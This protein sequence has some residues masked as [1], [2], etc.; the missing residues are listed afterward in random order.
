MNCRR[1]SRCHRVGDETL[2]EIGIWCQEEKNLL[3]SL[4]NTNQFLGFGPYRYKLG[5]IWTMGLNVLMSGLIR[6]L[7]LRMFHM[8]LSR[9]CIVLSFMECSVYVIAIKLVSMLFKASMLL[10][11][12]VFYPF[13]R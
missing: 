7:F 8:C 12:L 10:L 11:M 3:Q 1:P 4:Q 5:L 13:L 9:V 2:E 6:G